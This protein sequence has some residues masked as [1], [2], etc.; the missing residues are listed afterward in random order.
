MQRVHADFQ[1]KDVVTLAISIDGGGSKTVQ[2]FVEK[3]G[4]T[5]PVFVDTGMEIARKFGVR[6]LPMTYVVDRTGRVVASGFGPVDVDSPEFRSYLQTL[7]GA[8]KS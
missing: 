7:A 3:H 4:Y 2:T 5:M 8:K 6:G 1:D